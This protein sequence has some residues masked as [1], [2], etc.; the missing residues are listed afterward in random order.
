M[1]MIDVVIVK[2]LFFFDLGLKIDCWFKSWLVMRRKEYG[3][4]LIFCC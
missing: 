3:N 1:K 2:L 4:L